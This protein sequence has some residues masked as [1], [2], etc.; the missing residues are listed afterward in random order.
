MD[1]MNLLGDTLG[2]SADLF[3]DDLGTEGSILD[4]DLDGGLKYQT[5]AHESLEEL[6][7]ADTPAGN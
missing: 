6:L 3:A 7:L 4:L 5:A 2:F 1:Q